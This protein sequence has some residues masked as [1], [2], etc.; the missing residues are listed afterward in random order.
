M[1]GVEAV[2]FEIVLESWTLIITQRVHLFKKL[3]RNQVKRG[4]K[5]IWMGD[6]ENIDNII[7]EKEMEDNPPEQLLGSWVYV[8]FYAKSV[9][10]SFG[11]LCLGQNN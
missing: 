9:C 8:W 5:K 11:L 2:S 10:L 3:K 1:L 7:N 6:T 4:N